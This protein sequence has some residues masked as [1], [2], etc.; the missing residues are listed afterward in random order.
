MIRNGFACVVGEKVEF[1]YSGDI[2]ASASHDDA[3]IRGDT[4]S[5]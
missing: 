5:C 4:S 1:E 3:T 2:L